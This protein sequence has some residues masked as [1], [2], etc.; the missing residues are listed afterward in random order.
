M[1]S[2]KQK[3]SAFL[4]LSLFLLSVLPAGLAEEGS[5][6]VV[7]VELDAEAEVDSDAADAEVKTESKT[8][9]E[10]EDEDSE[11]EEETEVKT[12][13]NDGEFEEKVEVKTKIKNGL[14][15]R[16]IKREV[17]VLQNAR[18][19]LEGAKER[20]HEAKEKQREHRE[21]VLELHKR[22]RRCNAENEDCAALKLE[23]RVGVKNHLLK[24]VQVVERSLEKLTKTVEKM[25][26]LSEEEKQNALDFIADLEA[27]LTAQKAKIDSFTNET[28]QEEIRAAIKDLKELNQKVHK[29]QRRLVGLLVNAKLHILVEKHA[30]LHTS[31]QARIDALAEVG[32]D[33]SELEAILAEFDAKVAELEQDYEA[34]KQKWMEAKDA[35]DFDR[36]NRE[37][38][39]AQH[40]VRKDLQETKKILRDFLHTY[41]EVQQELKEGSK[42]ASE[43]SENELEESEDSD[44]PE[45]NTAVEADANAEAT[46]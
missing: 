40:E 41:K 13:E 39:A 25:E 33:V 18:E 12:G 1:T 29:L 45:S 10:T 20:F 21:K 4:V 36:F 46:A 3:L 16:E 42:D 19:R 43:E 9:V 28:S 7:D 44:E 27:E 37:L 31:M 38:R 2:I 35:E 6:N 5:N 22:A 24:S 17:K 30:D 34:A 14:I 23:L 15:K 8:E 11:V 32:A 26:D